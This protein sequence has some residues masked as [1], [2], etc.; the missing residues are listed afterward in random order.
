MTVAARRSDIAWA[1][2]KV[3]GWLTVV[4]SCA[5]CYPV[6]SAAVDLLAIV[7]T[8]CHTSKPHATCVN[9]LPYV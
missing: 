4:H 6:R 1:S 9:L 2:T 7:L 5:P 3:K 8:T